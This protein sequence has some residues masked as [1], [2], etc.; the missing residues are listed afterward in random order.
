MAQIEMRKGFIVK[1][2]GVVLIFLGALDSMLSW[3]GGL[4]LNDFYVW[5]M[6]AG[7]FLYAVGAV[8]QRSGA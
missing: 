5:L 8:R 6:G 1:L 2:F 7:L 4:A 3:R